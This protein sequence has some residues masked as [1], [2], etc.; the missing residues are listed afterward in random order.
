MATLRPCLGDGVGV[1]EGVLLSAFS[2]R[3]L[4]EEVKSTCFCALGKSEDELLVT[5]LCFSGVAT[6]VPAAIFA[7]SSE[8]RR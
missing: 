6:W 1:F 7:G 5:A 8:Y 2:Y 3:A 4:V